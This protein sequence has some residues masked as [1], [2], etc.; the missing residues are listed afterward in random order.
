MVIYECTSVCIYNTKENTKE[1]KKIS[2]LIADHWKALD[3]EMI[4][5]LCHSSR[6]VVFVSPFLQ[7]TVLS[8]CPLGNVVAVTPCDF[9]DWGLWHLHIPHL[10]S[11]P[12]YPN[13]SLGTWCH[14]A[15]RNHSVVQVGA[16]T[17]HALWYFS[18]MQD[19]EWQ[20]SQ[21]D[22]SQQIPQSRTA[23]SGQLRV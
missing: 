10:L 23:G 21:M 17:P 7:S 19:S 1:R 15:M 13:K 3:V 20:R 18:W 14:R 11:E 6:V 16:L 8:L 12:G 5:S 22:W 2:V 4:G 9:W